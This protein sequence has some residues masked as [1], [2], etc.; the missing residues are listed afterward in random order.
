MQDDLGV[1]LDRIDEAALP[2]G[3]PLDSIAPPETTEAPEALVRRWSRWRDAAVDPRCVPY[4]GVPDVPSARWLAFAACERAGSTWNEP[5]GPRQR[6]D[7]FDLAATQR[8]EQAAGRALGVWDVVPGREA[9]ANARRAVLE[10][11]L[12]HPP[13]ENWTPSAA[14]PEGLLSAPFVTGLDTAGLQLLR[15]VLDGPDAAWQWWEH[16]HRDFDRWAATPLMR[17]LLRGGADGTVDAERVARWHAVV[18]D[19]R[20]APGQRLRASALTASPAEHAALLAATDLEAVTQTFNRQP[21][22]TL[23][24]LCALA[25][26]LDPDD[27]LALIDRVD[28]HDDDAVRRAISWNH[29]SQ[30]VGLALALFGPDMVDRMVEHLVRMDR[31]EEAVRLSARLT[32]PGAVGGMLRIAAESSEGAPVARTWSAA[33]PAAVAAYDAE[34]EARSGADGARHHEVLAD[35]VRA[36]ATADPAFAPA[37]PVAAAVTTRVREVAA[38]PAL[39]ADGTPDWW[40]EAVAA[41]A[42]APVTVKLAKKLPAAAPALVLRVDDRRVEGALAEQVLV[43]AMASDP[44]E[45]PRPLVAAV[46]ARMRPADRDDAGGV[47]LRSWLGA[48]APTRDLRLFAAAGF[49]GADGTVAAVA[50]QVNR[51]LRDGDTKRAVGGLEVLTAA[52]SPASLQALAGIAGSARSKKLR[53]TAEEWLEGLAARQGLTAEELADRVV[54][55]LGLDARGLRTFDYGD[56][57]FRVA[58]RDGKPLVHA[59]DADGRPTGKAAAS[60]PPSRGTDDLDRVDEAKDEFKQ[61]RSQLADVVKIQ[62]ARLDRAV[63]TG[64][65]WTAA[66]H[67]AFVLHHPVMNA[68]TRPLVWQVD[69]S[70]GRTLVRV[71]EEGEYLTVDE[72]PHEPSADAVVSLAHPLDLDAEARA[73]W[74]AHLADHDL[75]PPVHQLGREVLGL[76]D[77]Q[78]GVDLSGLPDG[79]LPPTTLLGSAQKLGWRRAAV[80]SSGLTELFVLPFPPLGVAALLQVTGLQP[81]WVQESDDQRL[82]RVVVAP[83]DLVTPATAEVDGELTAALLDW[84]AAPARVVSEVRRSLAVLGERTGS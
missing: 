61:L 12:E 59:L 44:A 18:E 52:G 10:P 60:L 38:L 82:R 16:T 68:L 19:D 29:D 73:A 26:P 9:L 46:T 6:V 65:T 62:T 67:A 11:E 50:T 55:D 51:W 33:H 81:G 75:Q 23:A 66:D 42:T 24:T 34:R 35:V 54:P 83:L 32:G 28:A 57:R 56:R 48:G 17:A 41:E 64:R 31:A 79:A 77:G 74:E 3:R 58:V 20:V 25:L 30:P 72:E 2:E 4:G 8:T 36:L 63:A 37:H 43:A 76:P 78:S 69:G 39:D 22:I 49:L 21:V 53:E 71:D 13:L 70:D 7:V 15:W 40:V 80:A 1:V 5:R 27:R 45:G 47:V 84:R 14:A